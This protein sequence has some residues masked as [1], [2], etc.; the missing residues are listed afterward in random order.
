MVLLW[1]QLL[2]IWSQL[3]LVEFLVHHLK[4]VPCKELVALSL[5]LKAHRSTECC[6]LAVSALQSILRFDDVFKN[7]FREEQHL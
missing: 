6:I 4:Y 2:T 1:S 3:Q 5:L 7:V